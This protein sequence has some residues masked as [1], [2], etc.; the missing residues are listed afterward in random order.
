MFVCFALF[1]C[2]ACYLLFGAY[3]SYFRH[4]HDSSYLENCKYPS[5]AFQCEFFFKKLRFT[6]NFTKQ[7]ILNEN[8][9]TW[10]MGPALHLEVPLA[11]SARIKPHRTR[12]APLNA[13]P[14]LW[15]QTWKEDQ[16]Y[17]CLL[18]HKCNSQCRTPRFERKSNT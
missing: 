11:V 2:F 6:T 10:Q 17:H 14:A 5:P 4:L 12:Q 16:Q 13:G 3:I 7:A 8:A 15:F 1:V 9:C 18:L